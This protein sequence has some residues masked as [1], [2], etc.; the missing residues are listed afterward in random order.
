ME[1][2]LVRTPTK[3]TTCIQD[4]ASHNCQP[5]P[6]QDALSK[7]QTTKKIQPNHQQTGLPSFTALPIRGKKKTHLL[8]PESKHKSHPIWSLHK[9]LNQ[10]YEGRKQKK[11]RILPWSLGKG[12]VKYS[13]FLKTKRQRNTAQMKEQPRNTQ[14]QIHE[15]EIDKLPEKE[16][17]IMIIKIIQNLKN[18]MEQMQESIN[19]FSK[20]LGEIKN[21]QREINN[22]ITEIKNTLVWINNRVSEAEERMSE[23]ED[24]MVEITAEEQNKVKR[25]KSAEDSLRDLWDNSKHINIWII[26][27]LEEEKKNKVIIDIHVPIAI[28]LVGWGLFL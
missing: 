8:P 25:M 3:A 17:R 5:Q 11:E 16:F 19:T 2:Q 13:K 1:Y 20:D 10:P 14:V 22:S 9:P 15:E 23:L 4:P 6:M 18:R 28:F 24:R 27:V 26:K 7:Q 21:K 12:D